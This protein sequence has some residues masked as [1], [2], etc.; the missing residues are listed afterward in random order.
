M[1]YARPGRWYSFIIVGRAS[2]GSKIYLKIF[3]LMKLFMSLYRVLSVEVVH[4]SL[5]GGEQ[6]RL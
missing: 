4:S 2:Q 3:K 5:C 1:R 6:I